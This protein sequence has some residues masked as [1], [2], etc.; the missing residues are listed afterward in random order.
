MSE[1]NLPPHNAEIS[2]LPRAREIKINS[3]EQTSARTLMN[4]SGNTLQVTGTALSSVSVFYLVNF[5]T[6]LG[7]GVIESFP[8]WISKGFDIQELF[9]NRD[10]G[11]WKSYFVIISALIL[12]FSFRRIG[13]WCASESLVSWMEQRVYSEQT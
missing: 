9:T 10:V 3:N 6:S 11:S 12:G 2:E 13:T 4:A 8:L 5:S 7:R 1:N